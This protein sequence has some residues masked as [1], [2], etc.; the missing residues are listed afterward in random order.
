MD[1]LMGNDFVTNSEMLLLSS[2]VT[3]ELPLLLLMVVL[4]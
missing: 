2:G 4:E 1:W 3:E